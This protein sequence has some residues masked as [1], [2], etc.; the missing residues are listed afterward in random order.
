MAFA[1]TAS[2]DAIISF[3]SDNVLSPDNICKTWT[4][5]AGSNTITLTFFMSDDESIGYFSYTNYFDDGPYSSTNTA[6]GRFLIQ[7]NLI[8]ICASQGFNYIPTVYVYYNGTVYGDPLV[9]P[10][11]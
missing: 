3:S 10:L 4:G 6:S 1:T 7:G 8:L 9:G 2:T 11:H 5:Q